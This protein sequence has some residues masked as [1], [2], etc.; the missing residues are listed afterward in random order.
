MEAVYR[1]RG[2]QAGAG[3][4][5]AADPNAANCGLGGEAAVELDLTPKAAELFDQLWSA[6][7]PELAHLRAVTGSWVERQDALDRDRNHFLKAF[8]HKHGFDRADYSG[9][10]AS[11]YRS[12]LD[13]VNARTDAER[14][15]AATE[16]LGN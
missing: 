8:R 13:E 7:A 15:S 4:W 6:A 10:Q 2:A 3:L 5:S 1:S 14:R 12:G 11:A 9:E 16:L